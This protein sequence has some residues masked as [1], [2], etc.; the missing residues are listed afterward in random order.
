MWFKQ[1]H[2]L[3]VS[4]KLKRMVDNEDDARPGAQSLDID[5]TQIFKLN[6]RCRRQV[7]SIFDQAV[8]LQGGTFSVNVSLVLFGTNALFFFAKLNQTQQTSK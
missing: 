1:R 2:V 3:I 8:Q 6:T 4:L 5:E 7:L